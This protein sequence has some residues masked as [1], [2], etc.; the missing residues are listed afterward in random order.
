MAG[1]LT[2][3]LLCG[4]IA[5]TAKLSGGRVEISDD[6]IA[7]LNRGGNLLGTI[8][9]CELAKVTA[10]HKMGQLLLWDVAG[11]RRVSINRNVQS[12]DRIRTRILTEYAKVFKLSYPPIE[13]RRPT[14]W[15]VDGIVC[16]GAAAA[17]LWISFKIIDE[18]QLGSGLT[19]LCIFEALIFSYLLSINPQILGPSQILQDRIVL[20]NLFRSTLM[21]KKDV[22][23]VEITDFVAGR[24]GSSSMVLVKA[25]DGRELKLLQRYGSLPDM[26]LTLRAWLAQD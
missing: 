8:R 19:I 26:Y 16:L 23:S 10:T 6:G 4:L 17:A 5:K 22:A 1:I 13:L 3:L 15:T 9:W 21:Y 12:F 25:R 14:F 18:G 2:S 20:Q 11:N 7:V 24:S